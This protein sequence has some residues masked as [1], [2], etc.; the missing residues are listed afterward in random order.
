MQNLKL[1]IFFILISFSAN[2]QIGGEYAFEFLNVA[3]S[4]RQSALGGVNVSLADRD[5]NLFAA[6]PALAGDTL[7]GVASL[8]Y[9]FYLADIGHAFFSYAHD[10]KSVGQLMFGVQHFDYGEMQG[11]DD[12]GLETGRLTAG[13][14]ALIIGRQHQINHF[15]LGIN[16][17][18]VFSNLAGYRASAMAVDIGGIF[19][20]PDKFFT[21]GLTIKNLGLILSDYSGVN[22]SRLPFDIQAGATFKPEHMPLRF[23]LTAYNLTK[24][25]LTYYN[26]ATDSEKPK[27]IDKIL[28]H[29]NVGT[30]ILIHR[31][32]NL[33]VGYNFLTHRA[34][35][36]DTGGGGA[37]ISFGFSASIKSFEFVFS[38]SGY[39]AGNAGYSFTLSP[40]LNKLLKRQ[41]P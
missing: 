8:N 11:F 9:Q 6:N 16:L 23:S 14:T 30:E 41:Y 29:L 22:S 4:A 37:G 20:H 10:F 32:V 36:L 12:T 38:R 25:D 31:N 17:K 26:P 34:L 7:A 5:V 19:I 40:N 39:V 13:E 27:T 15:R 2:A 24:K 33:L 21:A 35:K 1:T 3:P 28:G 18:T